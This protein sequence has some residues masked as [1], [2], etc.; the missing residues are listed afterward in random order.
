MYVSRNPQKTDLHQLIRENYRQVFF[1]KEI[2]GFTLPFHL[3][4]EFK[5]YLTCGNLSYGMARFHCSLCQKDKLVAFSCKGRTL[6]PSCTSRRMSDT[7]KH[8]LEEVIPNVPTQS[9]GFEHAICISFFI[10]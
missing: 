4:R 7:A 10:G 8:L 5:K 9:V 3:E 1:N 2:N 6:C